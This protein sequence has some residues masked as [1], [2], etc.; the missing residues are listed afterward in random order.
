MVHHIRR[1]FEASHD[2]RGA[3]GGVLETVRV[4][5]LGGF[6]LDNCEHLID[7]CARFTERLLSSCPRVRV[8]ATS[9]EPLEVAG[10]I[11]GL[12][13]FPATASRPRMPLRPRLPVMLQLLR[14]PRDPSFRERLPDV[15][16]SG[17][18]RSLRECHI[19]PRRR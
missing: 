5:L 15:Q 13:E 2:T 8:L 14:V 18:A 3:R 17:P 1:T 12:V 7:A 19:L 10:E 11:E 6:R 16:P 4:W 9:R